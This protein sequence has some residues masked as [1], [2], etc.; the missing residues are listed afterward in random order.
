M[1][2]YNYQFGYRIDDNDIKKS[3]TDMRARFGNGPD[4][5]KRKGSNMQ[6]YIVRGGFVP[7]G[8]DDVSSTF[9]SLYI[10]LTFFLFAMHIY[11]YSTNSQYS[12]R[13]SAATSEK[14][15]DKIGI[16]RWITFCI[17][18]GYMFSSKWYPYD[19]C[20]WNQRTWPTSYK[21]NVEIK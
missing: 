14:T 4:R 1:A 17:L 7:A 21:R 6:C 8:D 9:I 10:L 2:F 12:P 13:S 19:S 20:T 5:R 15:P 16:L 18:Q 11:I 3:I